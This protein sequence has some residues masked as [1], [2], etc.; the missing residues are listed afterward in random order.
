MGYPLAASLHGWCVFLQDGSAKHDYVLLCS[1]IICNRSLDCPITLFCSV[2]VHNGQNKYGVRHSSCVLH[3]H[4]LSGDVGVSFH[5]PSQMNSS[6][7]G[8]KTECSTFSQC[9]M[10]ARTCS[11][12]ETVLDS[13]L[14]SQYN[15]DGL[16][17]HSSACINLPSSTSISHADS[18]N[19]PHSK[20]LINADI[21]IQDSNLNFPS[22]NQFYT[23]D[24]QMDDG[25]GDVQGLNYT[26]IPGVNSLAAQVHSCGSALSGYM[27]V[28]PLCDNSSG[29]RYDPLV[30]RS[31]SCQDHQIASTNNVVYHVASNSAQLPDSTNGD[32][33]PHHCSMASQYPCATSVSNGL[34]ALPVSEPLQELQQPLPPDSGGLSRELEDGEEYLKTIKVDIG[35]QCEVGPE[36]LQALIEDDEGSDESV[37]E[38]EHQSVPPKTLTQTSKLCV[39]CCF[40][41]G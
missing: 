33:F 39:Y 12:A 17:A 11:F 4:T 36:T 7:V 1:T 30:F 18:I 5:M 14:M 26:C 34:V 27:D 31:P 10:M 20:T 21:G 2:V 32:H 40:C 15:S 22:T 41:C 29:M 25:Y 3:T 35:I 23:V 24:G 8:T 6:Y 13:N 37:K 19:L 16:S 38:V 28:E 9:N